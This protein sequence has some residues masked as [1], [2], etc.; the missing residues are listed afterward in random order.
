MKEVRK[1]IAHIK[2][3]LSSDD[4]IDRV[5]RFV[6]SD[7][8]SILDVIEDEVP[9]KIYPHYQDR[10]KFMQEFKESLQKYYKTK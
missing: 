5:E 4:R 9:R 1:I 3:R 10:E 6:L 2:D 8:I 7:I